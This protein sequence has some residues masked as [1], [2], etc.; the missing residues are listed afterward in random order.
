[1]PLTARDVTIAEPERLRSLGDKRWLA[2]GSGVAF[3]IR[4]PRQVKGWNTG[5]T[6]EDGLS[7]PAPSSAVV[8]L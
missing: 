7:E 2:G 4:R 1:M 8:L 5:R 3:C 6:F